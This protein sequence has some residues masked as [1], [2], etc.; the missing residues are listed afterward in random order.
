MKYMVNNRG[1]KIAIGSLVRYTG[2][3][4]V[5]IVRAIDLI[6]GRYWALIDTTNLYYDI[7][8]LELVEGGTGEVAGGL[9]NNK[10]SLESTK[11]EGKVFEKATEVT[12]SGA[13]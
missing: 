13:G 6:E 8:Y 12:P 10:S 7:D 3:G 2:T 11:E 9:K 5:G 1:L 4:T